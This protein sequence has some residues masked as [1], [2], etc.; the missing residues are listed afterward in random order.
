MTSSNQRAPSGHVLLGRLGKTFKLA[1]ALRFR[2]ASPAAVDALQA[3]ET[4][5][6]SGV[7][8]LRVRDLELSEA[9]VLLYLESVR[10]RTAAQ[11]LVNAEVHANPAD[12]PDDLLAELAAAGPE[13]SLAGLA[14]RLGGERIGTVKTAHFGP[15]DYVEIELLNGDLVLAP[16]NAPYVVVGEDALDLIDPPPGLLAD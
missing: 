12:L 13:A 6:V 4:V 5:F 1:G 10:D 7:G 9:G 14:V 8:R 2:P 15:N 16:L 11:A 3:L